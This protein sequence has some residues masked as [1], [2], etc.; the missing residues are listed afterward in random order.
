M[1]PLKE[2]YAE[3]LSLTKLYLLQEYTTK[4]KILAESS[5]YTYFFEQAQQQ[6]RQNAAPPIQENKPTLTAPS[7]S[8]RPPA[9]ST[10]STSSVTRAMNPSAALYPP[11]PSEQPVPIPVAVAATP[12]HV[13][14]I[15][16][17]SSQSI[18]QPT[19]QTTPQP[20][21][22][23]TSSQK[24]SSQE[25]T[26]FKLEPPPALSPEDFKDL[27]KTI[28]EKLPRLVLLD[29]TP[30]DTAA[31]K[32]A[33]LWNQPK[34]M[35][36]VLILSLNE[37]PKQRAFL[38]NLV[39]ALQTHGVTA[40]IDNSLKTERD[41]QWESI[42]RAPELQLVVASNVGFD[43]LTDL[44]RLYK[45]DTKSGVHYAG[46]R[47]L[48]LLPDLSFYFKE[49]SLKASLWQNLKKWLASAPMPS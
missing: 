18:S 30:D 27:R 8:P 31:K 48:L 25:K 47:P 40:H 12:T 23:T 37:P 41:R 10:T 1:M 5:T 24:P 45:H 21:N 32:L 22:P 29:H 33:N 19:P 28:Q 38:D 46:E 2:Q 11:K 43:R 44:Q 4:D 17:S 13:P 16:K 20:T 7:L 36:R 39:K 26:H 15:S 6:K 9:T 34:Q 49:P 42:L 14:P 3:L 35:S